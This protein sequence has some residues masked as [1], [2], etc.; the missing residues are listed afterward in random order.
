MTLEQVLKHLN[1]EPSLES[2]SPFWEDSMA[3]L[4]LGVPGFLEP[5]SLREAMDYASVDASE[6]EPV[7]K[8]AEKIAK[9]AALKR[10]AWHCRRVLY[11]ERNYPSENVRAWPTLAE[12][13]GDE[14]NYFYFVVAL[15]A[16]DYVRAFHRERG[17]PEDI[18]RA[19][20][21]DSGRFRPSNVGV[22]V[23]IPGTLPW[24]RHKAV[25]DLFRVGRHQYIRGPFHGQLL[26]FRH[27]ASGDV[28]ALAEAGRCFG[29]SGHCDGDGG[30]CDPA[31]WTA[32][33][34][35]DE[36]R[37]VGF[38]ISPRGHAVRREVQLRLDEWA[39]LL[40]RD[41]PVLQMH[42][43]PADPMTLE[44]TAE[45]LRRAARF[46]WRYFPERPWRAFAC[47]SWVF[48]PQLQ[49]ILGEGSNIAAWQREEYLYPVHSPNP[50]GLH[51]IF[52]FKPFDL[53]TAPRD[54]RLRRGVVEL[55]ESGG[56]LRNGA[57]FAFPEDLPHFG[58][59]FYLKGWEKAWDR[60]MKDG[61]TASDG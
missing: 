35:M 57:M 36:K 33:L 39:L 43:P 5:S 50:A 24:L 26:A 28:V 49:G 15:A 8:M 41:T 34:Q 18:T 7:A 11:E 1:E 4:P 51:F 16:V 38:P 45:S 46:F 13:L 30:V 2:L 52:G 60:M 10:L 25:G 59:Q 53:A 47:G 14:A 54:T 19:T 23:N 56:P 6:H 22:R 48:N 17:V 12:A 58:S 40:V 9:D 29:S 3:C 31:A 37:A 61:S 42:I 44:A 32:H 27:R 20:C 21:T 55:L